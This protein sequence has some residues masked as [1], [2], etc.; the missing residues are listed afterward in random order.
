MS[1][2]NLFL[3]IS[4]VDTEKRMVFGYAST[5]TKD[6]QGEIVTLDAIK[7]ALPDYMQWRNIRVM[8]TSKAV[9]S[10]VEANVDEKGLYIGAKIRDDETWKMC[11][12]TSKGANDQVYRGFSIGGSKLQKT[13]DTINE[14]RLTE[15]SLVDR[16]ANSECKIDFAKGA[17]DIFAVDA[18][19]PE[20]TSIFQKAIDAISDIVKMAG[21]AVSDA[22]QSL[23]KSVDA[24]ALTADEVT[25]LNLKLAEVEFE[26]REFSE[27]Q[28]KHLASTGVALPDG[29][30]PIASEAD[31][32]N[33]VSAVGRAADYGKAKAHIIARAKTLKCTDQ[34]PADWPGSTK[35]EK[36]V[37]PELTEIQKRASAMQKASIGKAK[38]HLE[39]A[40]A[41]HGKAV[42]SFND[43]AKCMGK[44]DG[45]ESH[46]K[47]MRALGSHLETMSDHHDLAMHH[48]SR[49]DA[50]AGP[51]A[52][53]KNSEGGDVPKT[54]TESITV[55]PQPVMTEGPVEGSDYRGAGDSPYSAAAMAQAVQK[56]VSD[57]LVPLNEKLAK[58][59]TDNA[60]MKGQ[61][62]VLERMPSGQNRP[63]MIPGMTGA[64]HETLFG[65]SDPTAQVNKEIGKAY[66]QIS[67][68]DPD[69][70]AAATARIIGLRAANPKL[71]GKSLNSGEVA[72][73]ALSK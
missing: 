68:D 1:D 64:G 7:G 51:E 26:K 22:N 71:F 20:D 36:T 50:E 72:P 12:E 45:A 59:E 47:H 39:K 14:L 61:M 66:A 19:I 46:E 17:G 62:A 73:L 33:A 43:M 52:S 27:K 16:P 8:H 34:L 70:T 28:R 55:H 63:R 69:G 38:N 54:T 42:N 65:A 44:A 23:I 37:M 24:D 29:S 2:F 10:T 41:A 3:P 15:I 48:L 11:Q 32:K 6:L 25:D 35:Q 4:K 49:A 60:F 9:G 56:A 67:E 40:M 18:A 21:G 31:L 53:P 5:P 57:A 13:G 58:A 30:Y